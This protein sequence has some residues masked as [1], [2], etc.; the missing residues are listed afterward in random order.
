M[1][2]DS[3]AEKI[4]YYFDYGQRKINFFIILHMAQA[5][6]RWLHDSKNGINVSD[7]IPSMK[8][9]QSATYSESKNDSQ[10]I[11]ARNKKEAP[12]NFIKQF[13]NN[14]KDL[15]FDFQTRLIQTWKVWF[16]N[17]MKTCKY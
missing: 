13:E 16:K 17:K 5:E 14:C 4:H 10:I 12:V 11:E 15:T 7:H 1:T 9:F 8:L 6:W 2:D 3:T